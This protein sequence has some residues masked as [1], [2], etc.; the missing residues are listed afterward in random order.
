MRSQIYGIL[1]LMYTLAIGILLIVAMV[2][3]SKQFSWQ[4]SAPL[5]RF[6][7]IALSSSMNKVK[8]FLQQERV[9]AVDRAL[10]YTGAFGGYSTF[11]DLVP[12][13]NAKWC[14]CPSGTIKINKSGGSCTSSDKVCYCNNTSIGKLVQPNMC[15]VTDKGKKL[16]IGMIKDK[17][18]WE[19]FTEKYFVYWY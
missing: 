1:G 2:G 13:I 7:M 10:F 17:K 5:Y 6:S 11:H 4:S 12:R 9:Y 14:G 19:M 3:T 16:D 15:F 18:L 8:T